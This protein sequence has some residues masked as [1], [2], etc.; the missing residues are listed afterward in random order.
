MASN[1]KCFVLALLSTIALPTVC[2][3]M[4]EKA[5]QLLQ[6]TVGISV[7]CEGVINCY[8]YCGG[9]S[10]AEELSTDFSTKDK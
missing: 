1:P 10:A 5:L 3:Y 2:C 6:G 8:L 7:A 9:G 4:R